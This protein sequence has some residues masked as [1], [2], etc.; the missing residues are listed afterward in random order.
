MVNNIKAI[1][2]EA[3]DN[4]EITSEI[5]CDDTHDYYLLGKV[6]LAKEILNQLKKRGY[7][8]NFKYCF[9]R[10]EKHKYHKKATRL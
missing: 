2:Q 8:Q 9:R 4:T 6:D 7:L 10:T 1:C 5:L 3:I